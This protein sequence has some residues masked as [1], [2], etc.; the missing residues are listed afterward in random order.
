MLTRPGRRG[1]RARASLRLPRTRAAACGTATRESA[2]RCGPG[3]RGRACCR[4]QTTRACGATQSP[5]PSRGLSMPGFATPAPACVARPAGRCLRATRTRSSAAPSTTRV[6]SSSRVRAQARLSSPLRLVQLLRQ[7]TRLL[8]RSLDPPGRR[9][10]GQHVPH[11]EGAHSGVG[12]GARR[13]RRGAGAG[14]LRCEAHDCVHV[15]GLRGA[16]VDVLSKQRACMAMTRATC[17]A[18]ACV[19]VVCCCG[20]CR[21]T[22]GRTSPS[23]GCP[24]LRLADP[25]PPLCYG[26]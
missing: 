8:S 15:R 5:L 14:R 20:A 10:Q 4:A 9:L 3:A 18:C 21:G 24:L 26:R 6:T 7:P 16:A 12:A 17:L 22:C 11:L 1:R 23:L 25:G 13:H 19:G 2:C